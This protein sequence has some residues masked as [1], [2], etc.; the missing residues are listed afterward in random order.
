MPGC[1]V[2]RAPHASHG[3]GPPLL[4]ETK[5][6]CG[7]CV[8][9]QPASQRSVALAAREAIEDGSILIQ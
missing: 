6:Y 3:I 5:H 9:L 4:P 7:A 8:R 2:C 1:C